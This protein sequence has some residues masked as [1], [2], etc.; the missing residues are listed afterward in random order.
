[1]SVHIN[2]EQDLKPSSQSLVEIASP[3]AS[4]TQ[5]RGHT[6]LPWRT[7]PKKSLRIVAGDDDTV[8]SVGSQASLRGQWEGNALLIVRAVNN[9]SALIEML[10]EWLAF[11]EDKFGEFDIEG[12]DDCY[13][14]NLC[15]QCQSN[16]CIQYKIR[17]TRK[18]IE[19]NL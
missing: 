9:H 8:A 16:G 15:P 7:D 10:S 3:A 5:E 12:E 6:Q 14:E 18:L 2:T 19:A 17:R 11:A 4:E 1:M 13:S